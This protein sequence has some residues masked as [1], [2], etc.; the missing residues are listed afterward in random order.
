MRTCRR[1]IGRRKASEATE[2]TMKTI[3]LTIVP[4]P[5]S[6]G[7]RGGAGSKREG[8][9]EEQAG[10]HHLADPEQDRDRSTQISHAGIWCTA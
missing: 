2:A 4:P 8:A 6:R 3:R 7:K 5:N 9:E 10:R 1:A